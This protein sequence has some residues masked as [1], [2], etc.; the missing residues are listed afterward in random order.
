[1]QRLR[2]SSKQKKTIREALPG[3]NFKTSEY[4]ITMPTNTNK[5]FYHYL[6]SKNTL[7]Y[8]VYNNSLLVKVSK[9]KL[10]AKY[11]VFNKELKEYLGL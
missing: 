6:D 5:T 1:M 3:S 9:Q 2:L 4:K 11:A 7:Y 8:E 10:A